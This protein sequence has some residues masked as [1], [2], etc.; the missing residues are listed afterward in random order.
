MHYMYPNYSYEIQIILFLNLFPFTSTSFSFT[1][2]LVYE[3]G[4]ESE[5]K[6]NNPNNLN[7]IP[8]QVK[9]AFLC[10]SS[11]QFSFSLLQPIFNSNIRFESHHHPISWEM[12]TYAFIHT[13]LF[14]AFCLA[15]LD[16]V[17]YLYS[18][19]HFS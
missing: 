18:L 17:V 12:S 19:S 7:S 13:Y 16:M 11:P 10:F 1:C 8:D 3:N 14:I 9:V 15:L 6:R 2:G 4:D 5:G